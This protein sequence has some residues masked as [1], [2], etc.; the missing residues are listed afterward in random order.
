MNLEDHRQRLRDAQLRVQQLRRVFDYEVKL[1]ELRGIEHKMSQ[2]G[3]WDSQER[4]QATML[5]KQK[6]G[7]I[8]DPIDKST[9][10]L[11][12]MTVLLELGADDPSSVDAD[13]DSAHADLQRTLDA[14]EFQVMLSGEHDAK[15]AIITIAPGAG[16]IDAQDWAEMLVRMYLKWAQD[17]GF[18][19]EE[20]DWQKGEEAGIRV[21]TYSVKGAYA[22][23]RLRAEQGVHRLVRISPFDGQGRRQTSFASL[24]VIPEMDD[25]IDIEIDEKDL[26]IDTYRSSGAGGQH[27]NKT[28]SAIRIT[29]LPTGVVVTC[30]QER[31][32][33][34][35]RAH[36]MK[37][38]RSKLYQ[39]EEAKRKEE[40]AKFYGERGSIS[41]GNQ[42]RSYVLQPYQM[43]KDL[44]TGIETS[45]V[46]SV[47][48]GELD[49]FIEAY[50]K[51][52][53]V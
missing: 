12:D 16:G 28:E 37:V 52:V 49:Q 23:G 46:D 17:H 15:N 9:A 34:K 41:W 45:D 3:F 44:R 22:Y 50:L 25:D 10:I 27:V 18:E 31:S 8:V 33:H 20:Q 48:N 32:Q 36:A 43:V 51:G 26:K 39:I 47:L 35:N 42:I 19:V 6:L 4:A 30:Q 40:L 5:E 7:S 11:D 29:H 14:L 38:L 24:E 2:P 1:R 13:L 21:A 53:R